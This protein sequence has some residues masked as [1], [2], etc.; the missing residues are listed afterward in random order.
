MLKRISCFLRSMESHQKF[1]RSR[2]EAESELTF[3]ITQMEGKQ[4]KGIRETK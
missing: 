1:M 3:E 2:G 4:T